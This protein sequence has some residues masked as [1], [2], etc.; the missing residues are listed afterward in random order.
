MMHLCICFSDGLIY[1]T[2]LRE[3]KLQTKPLDKFRLADFS[4][5]LKCQNLPTTPEKNPVAYIF[6]L[7]SET[8]GTM[9]CLETKAFPIRNPNNPQITYG[10]A[11][12][13]GQL[14]VSALMAEVQS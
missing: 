14:S 10:E 9:D 11:D 4:R 12:L 8:C 5:G 6:R 7:F 1:C 3:C 13:Y 2:P